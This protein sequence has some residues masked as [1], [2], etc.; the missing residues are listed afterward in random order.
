MTGAGLILL[1]T[2]STV[3]SEQDSIGIS[4]ADLGPLYEPEAIRFSFET[5]G[6]YILAALVL[7]VAIFFFYKWIINYKR[8]AYRR[9]ALKNLSLIETRFNEQKD[10]FCLNDVL[11]LLKLVA[12]QAFGRKLVAE[13][14]GDEWLTFLEQK[15][16]GTPFKKYSST[17]FSI[18]YKQSKIELNEV[19]NIIGLTHKWIKNHA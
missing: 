18:A 19:S 17:I 11:V 3:F 10:V 5:P 13:L 14:S 16:T 6:W 4:S 12:I 8:N 2:N 9:E 1:F 7:F 15:G